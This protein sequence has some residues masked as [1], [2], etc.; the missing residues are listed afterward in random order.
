MAREGTTPSD[1][2]VAPWVR[3]FVESP[4]GALPRV[5]TTWSVPERIEHLRCRLGSFR[6]GYAIRPGLYAVGDPGPTSDVFVTANY[7]LSFD[8]VRRALH[9]LDAWILVL[10]THG[11]NVWC[12]AGKGTFG[13][14]EL[15]RRIA[16]VGLEK[17]VSHRRLVVPQLG[18]P[19]IS[20]HEVQ[21]ATRFRV[22]FGPVRASDLPA[23]VRG[24]HVADVE[25]RRVRFGVAERVA[26][27][28][29]ELVPATKALVGYAVAAVLLF[30]LG[31]HGID[32][33][34]VRTGVAVAGLGLVAVLGGAIV[35][36]LL[37]PFIPGRAFAVKGSIVGI[38]LTAAYVAL[39]PALARDAGT[40]SAFA[41]AFTPAATSY[42]A[43]QFT[44]STT[45]TSMSGVK[46]ELRYALP[47]HVVALVTAIVLLVMH[48][49]ATWSAT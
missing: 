37:L 16:A 4:V 27:V 49:A 40:L 48:R 24:G 35:T 2:R 12:A 39:V 45:F 13:T 22:H 46:K 42:L 38:A 1:R 18:A 21:R 36:P 6:N 3:G 31:P 7:K 5:A 32:R 47:V 29:M 11:V 33:D 43:L 44:G 34:G 14:E 15:V 25:M 23:Y 30:G 8:H 17:V 26:L 10:D 20:A 19:G 28:P 41:G 9:G